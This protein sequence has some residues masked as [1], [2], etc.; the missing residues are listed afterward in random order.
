LQSTQP[1]KEVDPMF[2]TMKSRLR[3]VLAVALVAALVVAG[4]ALGQSNGDS[5]QGS[6][7]AQAG[8]HQ[9]PPPGPPPGGPMGGPQGK[10]LTYAEFHSYKDGKATVNRLD[11]GKIDSVSDS[12]ITLTENDGNQVTVPVDDGTKVL[13]GPGNDTS[14]SDLNEGQQVLVGHPENGAAD[15]ICI[16]PKPGQRPPHGQMP[17]GPP[18]SGSVPGAPG[19]GN[20]N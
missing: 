9:G 3:T 4:L 6:G 8:T 2:N 16:P 11:A 19:T 7:S 15:V 12:E 18:P 17:I 1:T 13:A 5:S 10:N 14:V 20:S